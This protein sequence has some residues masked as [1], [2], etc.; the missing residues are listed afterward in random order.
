MKILKSLFGKEQPQTPSW[1]IKPPAERPAPRVRRDME[2]TVPLEHA[3]ATT[4]APGP[5]NPQKKAEP[6]PFLDDPMLDTMSL[7]ADDLNFPESD[8]YQTSTWEMDPDNDTRKLRTFQSGN[9]ADKDKRNA[10][11][12]YDTGKMKRGW[13]K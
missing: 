2:P 1:D 12:P 3:A 8:P 7:E 4:E 13:K 9:G 10:F 5:Q 11:N 6:N